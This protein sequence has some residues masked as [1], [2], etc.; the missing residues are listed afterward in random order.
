MVPHWNE[1]ILCTMIM[2]FLFL[3]VIFWKSV[4]MK[5]MNSLESDSEYAIDRR[6]EIDDSLM[7]L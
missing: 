6:W 1:G 3:T 5:H 4:Y 2:A 7:K